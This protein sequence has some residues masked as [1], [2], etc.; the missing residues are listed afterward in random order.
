[1]EAE[2]VA[3]ERS[4]AEA[5]RVEAERVV[6]EAVR[7]E[8]ERLAAE[9]IAAAAA[10]AEAARAEAARAEAARAEAERAEHI[11]AEAA[12][13]AEHIAAEAARAAEHIAPV[14][15]PSEPSTAPRWAAAAPVTGDHTR[16]DEVGPGKWTETGRATADLLA[17]LPPRE[18]SVEDADEHY[19]PPAAP[20][21]TGAVGITNSSAREGE[22]GPGK[23]TASGRGV[24]ELMSGLP[25]GPSRP[26]DLDAD[27][28][29]RSPWLVVVG[30]VAL[31]AAAAALL[32][33]R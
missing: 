28:P 3:A 2:R 32:A 11:A 24:E 29:R 8:A 22:K 23:W 33:T 1:V 6:A 26:L 9:D 30:F 10:R 7:M 20:R 27:A 19:R 16:G 18:V 31:A 13:A 21:W 25:V 5:A 4:A 17:D 14:A 15:A 12:R